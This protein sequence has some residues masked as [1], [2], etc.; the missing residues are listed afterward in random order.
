ME[1]VDGLLRGRALVDG[2]FAG[3]FY[4]CGSARLGGVRCEVW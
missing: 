4:M 2:L 3:H 1:D